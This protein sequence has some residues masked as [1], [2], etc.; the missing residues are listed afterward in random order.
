MS[1]DPLPTSDNPDRRPPRKVGESLDRL[2][3]NLGSPVAG[4][5]AG[6]FGRWEELVGPRIAEHARPVAVKSGALVVVVDDHAWAAEL[7]WLG[8]ELVERIRSLLTDDSIG[9]IEVRTEP[10]DG[11]G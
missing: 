7:R 5:V 8:P 1:P 3:G 6:L 4:T 9:R 11:P 2:L 10:G